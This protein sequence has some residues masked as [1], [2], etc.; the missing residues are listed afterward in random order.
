[1][2]EPVL[3]LRDIKKYYPLPGGGLLERRPPLKAVD[4]VTLEVGRGEAMGLVGETGCGKTTLARVILRLQPPTS[5]S[6]WYGGTDVTALN[7]RQMRPMRRLVQM[8]FQDPSAALNPRQTLRDLLSAPLDALGTRT[9]REAKLREVVDLVGLP[10][11]FLSKYPHEMSGGQRQRAAIARAMAS[12]PALLVCDE[13]VSALDGSARGQIL[14]MMR[15]I[16]E[17]KGVSYL[18]ISHDLGAVR[19]LCQ[20]LAVMYLGGIVEQGTRQDIFQHP[21]HPYTKALLS[22]AAPPD[23]LGEPPVLLRGEAASPARAPGG[24]AFRTRCLYATVGCAKGRYPLTPL[25]REDGATHSSACPRYRRD[26]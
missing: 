12:E 26:L 5:G 23:P 17:E 19:F 7:S 22:A 20:R 4:G 10:V 18:F 15:R 11:S 14:Q 13:P 1:M 16:Q 9:G 25:R 2:P 21:A 3:A 24:C 8:I 6:V